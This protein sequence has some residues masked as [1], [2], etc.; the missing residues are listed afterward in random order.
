MNSSPD[1]RRQARIQ[2]L[3]SVYA[4]QN[5]SSVQ[6]LT[7]IAGTIAGL[8]AGEDDQKTC[9][10]PDKEL[11]ETLLIGFQEQHVQAEQILQGIMDTKIDAINPI[12]RAVLALAVLEMLV[13]PGTPRAVVINEWMEVA[14]QFGAPKGHKLIN[15]ILD[16]IPSKIATN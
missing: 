2:A 12:E 5:Q 13:R 15:A 9:T 4:V 6:N 7:A 10:P 16:S 8:I 14:K 11:L 3:Q 1:T